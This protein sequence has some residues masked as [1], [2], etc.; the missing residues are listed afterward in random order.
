M[1]FRRAARLR[2]RLIARRGRGHGMHVAIGHKRLGC[3]QTG[4]AAMID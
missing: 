1:R 3:D 2:T 4:R